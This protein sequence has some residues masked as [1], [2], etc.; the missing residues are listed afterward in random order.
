MKQEEMRKILEI[1]VMLSEARDYHCL[2]D[3]ILKCMMDL[4]SCDAGTLYLKDGDTLKSMI[5][6]NNTFETYF[7][8]DG[9]APDMA[10]VSLTKENVCALAF[11]EQRTIRMDDIKLCGEFDFSGPR[12]YDEMTGYHTRSMLVVPIASQRGGAIGVLQLIN[13]M[14]EQGNVCGFSEEMA[15]ILESLASQAAITIQNVQYVRDIKGLFYSFVRLMSSAIDERS[16]YNATHSRHMVACGAGFLDYI[17]KTAE[18]RG[19]APVFNARHREEVLMSVWLHDVGKLVTPL[20]VMDKRARLLPEQ[21]ASFMHRMEKVRLLS[22]LDCVCGR[23][24]KDQL[25]ETMAKIEEAIT[26]VD[27]TNIAGY[28]PDEAI[29]QIDELAARTYTEED[30]TRAAWL[31]PEEHTMLSIRKGTLSEKE[32]KTME[33]HVVMT[34]KFLSQIRFSEDL[35]HVPDWASSHH[36]FLDG[37]GYPAHLKGDEIPYEVRIITILD[38]F[39]A[40]VAEDRPYKPGM[41]VESA[42]FILTEMVQEG[43]LDAELVRLFIESKCWERAGYDRKDK[44]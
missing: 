43:K 14:D 5:M 15:L 40:I 25:N 10:P 12:Q 8:G 17:N 23:I 20:E 9:V 31:T 32:R 38:I 39:D 4:A 36:E 21:Y 24:T 19:E 18:S 26:L 22:K 33:N 41:P 37:S 2:L 29:G 16:P 27:W 13:A 42:L 3:Q 34:R 1:G 44:T 35:S 30:G 6:R 11:L 28:L 7:G